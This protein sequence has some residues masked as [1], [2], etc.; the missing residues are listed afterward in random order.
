L[1]GN[2][3]EKYRSSLNFG[4]LDSAVKVMKV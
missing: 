2:V 3:S 4:L 1:F